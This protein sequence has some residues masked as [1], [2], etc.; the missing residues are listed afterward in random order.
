MLT[1]SKVDLKINFLINFGFFFSAFYGQ[2][3][4]LGRPFGGK[5][6]LCDRKKEDLKSSIS[7]HT[8]RDFGFFRFSCTVKAI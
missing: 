3:R 7:G 4:L 1:A 8:D 5:A 6:N 2:K